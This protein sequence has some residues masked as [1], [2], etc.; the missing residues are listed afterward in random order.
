MRNSP[1]L[2]L[3]LLGIFCSS[4]AGNQRV[5]ET[6]F[7]QKRKHLPGWDLV[8][9]SS[10]APPAAT[11]PPH[12]D[13]G[14]EA[15]NVPPED[16]APLHEE[17]AP[18]LSAQADGA[19]PETMAPPLKPTKQPASGLAAHK[20]DQVEVTATKMVKDQDPQE[21]LMPKK[22]WNKF[23][24]PAFIAALGTLYLGLFTVSTLAVIGAILVTFILAGISLRQIRKRDEAGKGFALAALMLALLA[25]MAT[26]MVTY[27]VGFV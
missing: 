24:I 5:Q 8:L 15:G 13:I 22:R 9:R 21:N 17:V 3:L 26:A 16:Y 12:A 14:P 11:R 18:E 10:K 1:L 25:A 4:C 2:F 20:S 6:G 23:A 7:L 27:V 19:A